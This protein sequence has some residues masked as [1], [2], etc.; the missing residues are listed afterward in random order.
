M[1]SADVEP[2]LRPTELTI[3]QIRALAD[4]YACLCAR[5]PG[6]RGFEYR[7]ELK[8][9]RQSRRRSAPIDPPTSA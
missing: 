8:Q 3:P 4:A 9:K 6:L 5:E 7:E 1:Q 2:T